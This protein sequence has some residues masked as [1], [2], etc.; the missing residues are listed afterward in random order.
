MKKDLLLD[1]GWTDWSLL[2]DS[3]CSEP[4]GGG[5]QT[6]VRTCTNPKPQNGGKDCEGPDHKSVRCNKESCEGMHT[7]KNP[8]CSTT[9]GKGTRERVK[10]CVNGE[11]DGYKCDKIK[12]KSHKVEECKEWSPFQRDKC[13]SPC[14]KDSDEYSNIE[15]LKHCPDRAK[16]TDLSEDTGPKRNCKCVMGYELD[17]GNWK[18]REKPPV[19]PTPR[20]IPVLSPVSISVILCVIFLHKDLPE[21]CT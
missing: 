14:D 10:K 18:C 13:P 3:D 4:C 1:G 8:C 20:P 7:L 16:C 15:K 17:E 11:D 19:K 5:E 2:S 6:Q 12:D 21:G 9:C